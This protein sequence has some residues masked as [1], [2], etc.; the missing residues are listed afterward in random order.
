MKI[1][2]SLL[3]STALFSCNTP[4]S[5]RTLK[6]AASTIPHSEIL[7]VIKEDLYKEGI[8]LEIIEIDDYNIP[9]RLLAEKQ[10]DANFFQH[11]P[12][13]NAQKEKLGYSIESLVKIHLEPLGIYSDNLTALEEIPLNGVVAIPNDPSNEARAL[14]LLASQGLI[15]LKPNTGILATPLDIL[16]NPKNLRF[17]E[18]DAPFLPRILKDV[19]IAIIPG[20]FALLASYSPLEDALILESSQD[21]PYANIIAIENSKRDDDSILCL[22]KYLISEKVQSFILNKYKGGIT[23]A[24]IADAKK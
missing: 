14:T 7:E 19:D 13:L 11:E 4:S 15:T 22:K 2:L 20:N 16:Y 18:V 5:H 17:E 3:L 24:F 12:F 9:N 1:F 6:V 8:V 21:S 23:P 10:I